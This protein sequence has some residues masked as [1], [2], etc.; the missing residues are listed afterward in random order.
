MDYTLQQLAD[1]LG[2]RLAGDPSFRVDGVAEL[3]SAGPRDLTF[4]AD[5]RLL[6][7]VRA[8]TAGAVVVGQDFPG[9]EGVNLLHVDHPRRAFVQAVEQMVQPPREQGISPAA[10]IDPEAVLADGVA[11]GPCAVIGAGARIGAGTRIGAGA[12]V[13]PGVTVGEAGVIGPNVSLLHGVVLGDRVTVHAGSV[14]GGDGFGYLWWEDHHHKVPQVGTVEIGD[15]VEI[16]CNCCIDRATL[17][18]TRIGRGSKLDNLVHIAHNN[19]IGEDVVIAGQSG[20]A[21]S[22]TLGDRAV[23]AGQVGVVDHVTVGRGVVVGGDSVVTKDVPDGERVMGYPARPMR[24]AKR[25]LAVVS[26]LPE[27]LQ[28]VREQGRALEALARRLQELEGDG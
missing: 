3:E 10:V 21:G 11:V 15:D 9:L 7:R 26:R 8:G 14:I 13:G 12:Y 25:E 20:T 18:A 6:E 16:G 22:V 17:G 4:A 19:R 28:Q 1:L 24:R 27:L 2:A 23:L 5:R